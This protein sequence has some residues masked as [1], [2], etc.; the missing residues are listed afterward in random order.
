MKIR[1]K[2]CIVSFSS[3]MQECHYGPYSVK[4][5]GVKLRQNYSTD[6]S[7]RRECHYG[8]YSV[9]CSG[10]KL[11]Q[12]YSTDKSFRRELCKFLNVRGIY[13]TYAVRLGIHVVNHLRHFSKVRTS[14]YL[15]RM[16]P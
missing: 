10:V 9:K 5:S 6:K 3:V 4:C 11:R 8:P 1:V 16:S 2:Y 7:F 15:S 12:N 14:G 13:G